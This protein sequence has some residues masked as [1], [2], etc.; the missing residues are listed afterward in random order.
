MTKEITLYDFLWFNY[1]LIHKYL[2]LK[3]LSFS[4]LKKSIIILDITFIA[5][6]QVFPCGY[7]FKL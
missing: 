3:K 1:R 2:D 7:L 4:N 5:T 6:D